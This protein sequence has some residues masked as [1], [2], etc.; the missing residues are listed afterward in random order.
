MAT[1]VKYRRGERIKAKVKRETKRA[2]A[3][4]EAAKNAEAEGRT[5]YSRPGIK[6]VVIYMP[7]ATWARLVQ[8]SF[9]EKRDLRSV[10]PTV[11]EIVEEWLDA[12]DERDEKAEKRKRA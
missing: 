12:S 1:R 11:V 5:E 2:K 10:S 6:R 8:R 7:V 9:S 3:A 4:V